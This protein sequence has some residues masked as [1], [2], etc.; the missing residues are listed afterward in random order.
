M[1]LTVRKLVTLDRSIDIDCLRVGQGHHFLQFHSIGHDIH[2][3]RVRRTIS[4][5]PS[6]PKRLVS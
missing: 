6:E 4:S 3:R 1:R 5:L 2:C